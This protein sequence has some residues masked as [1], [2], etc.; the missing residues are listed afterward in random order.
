MEVTYIN[1]GGYLHWPDNITT[2]DA[3]KITRVLGGIHYCFTV[4]GQVPSMARK[5]KNVHKRKMK[6]EK[7]KVVKKKTLL[8]AKTTALSKKNITSI[9]NKFLMEEGLS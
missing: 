5:Y 2:E 6:R 9:I 3:Q 1:Q 8:L 7:S 4:M